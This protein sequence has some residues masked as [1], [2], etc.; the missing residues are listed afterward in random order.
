MEI[1][2]EIAEIIGEIEGAGEE[3]YLVGGAP[4]NYLLSREIND[5]DIATSSL[6]D[7]TEE[8]FRDYRTL[9][10]GKKFGTILLIYKGYQVEITSF[11]REGAYVDGRRPESVSF[12]KSLRED[13]ARRDFTINA[14]AYNPRLG[15]VDYFKG[16]E[17]L[18]Q[19]LIRTVGSPSERLAEDYL[20]ILRAIRFAVELEFR[21]EGETFKYCRIYGASLKLI[22]PER[23]RDELFKIL[24]APKPSQ[25]I[26]LLREAG[27]LE[28]I[29]PDLFKTIDF[30]QD[31]PYHNKDVYR[32]SLEVL[33]GSPRDLEIR[34]AALFHDLGKPGTK[35]LDADG[36]GHFYG[37][38]EL[39]AEISRKILRGFNAPRKL[40]D[41]V[42]LLV[43]DHMINNSQF[44]AKGMKRLIGKHGQEGVFKLLELQKADRLASRKQDISDILTMEEDLLDIISSCQTYDEKQLAIDGRDMIE[45]GY[46]EGKI[47]GEILSYALDLVL[48]DESL[49]KKDILLRIIDEKFK[50]RREA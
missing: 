25:G 41:R 9:D 17:D 47:I 36:C 31:T 19:G 14:L 43:R 33:D 46:K 21:I 16:L 29:L 30:K 24:L 6:P 27:I 4:R 40:I 5:Y 13:L 22:S 50:D 18:E 35:T 15:L 44:K 37:H 23:I 26:E 45:L 34:L 42:A 10:I 7:R 11:R 8:I 3:A 39:G 48:G 32:H 1:P 2:I 38:A 49:N 20:R 12:S 28:I